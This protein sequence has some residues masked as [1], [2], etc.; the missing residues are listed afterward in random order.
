MK[1]SYRLIISSFFILISSSIFSVSN[2]APNFSQLVS[3][4]FY[5]Q[6][7]KITQE[8]AYIQ[9]D[10]PY[11]NAGEDIWFKGYVLNAA[12]HIPNS[13]S[14]FLYVEL[15]DKSDSVIS[16]VK[17]RKDSLGFYGNIKLNP[18]LQPGM[19]AIR[20]YTYYMQN[21][22]SDFFFSKNI[23]IGNSID[24]RVN[25]NIVYGKTI[26]NTIPVFLEFKNTFKSPIVDRRVKITYNGSE[27]SY[28]S[29]FLQTNKDG[30]IA[31]LIPYDSLLTNKYIEVRIADDDMKYSKKF[32]IPDFRNDFDLQ[33]F[34]ESGVFLNNI[35]QTIA[36]KAIGTNGLSTEITG[37]L[38]NSKGEEISDINSVNKGMGKFT[39]VASE[40]ETYYVIVKNAKGI[41]K[42]FELSNNKSVGIG[43]HMGKNRGKIYYQVFNN[44]ILPTNEYYLLIHSRGIPFVVQ[45]INKTE[46]IIPEELLPSGIVSFA[47]LDSLGNTYCERLMFI[48][49]NDQ[50]IITM[51]SD[52][53]NYAK[54][55]PVQLDF[56]IKSLRQKPVDGSFSISVTDS[57][58][59]KQ[60][61]L[62]NNI[63]SYF[64]LS[65][66]IKG[67]IEDPGS[68][69]DEDQRISNEKI[70]V[71]LLTQGWRRFSTDDIA[72]G[73]FNVQ[74][75][76]AEV[77]QAITGKVTNIFGKP[78]VNSEIIMLLGY[79]NQIS[80][81][82]T[83]SAG[84]YLIDGIE[85]PDSTNIVLKAKKY[86]NLADVEITP[87]ADVF[88]ETNMFIPESTDKSDLP[89]D[90]YFLQT[91][92]KYYTDGGMLVINL[93]ELT[94]KAEKK[95][96]NFDTDIYSGMASTQIKS[97][98]LEKYPGMS[99]LDILST[100][101]GVTVMGDEVSIRGSSHNP[102]FMI[103]GIETQE[104]QDLTYLTST[105]IESISVF[106]G[107]DAAIFGSKGGSGAVTI[108]LKKGA[109]IQQITP[110]SL[111]LIK[112]L[113]YQKPSEFYV[114]KYDVDS[115]LI[116]TKPDLR[117]TIYWNPT[118]VADS[119]GNVHVQFYTADKA[120]NYTLVFEGITDKGE[121]CRFKGSIR[122]EGF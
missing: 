53:T 103:D 60:D 15:L 82:K 28:K 49:N 33:F 62:G 59:V 40:N 10:K 72:K 90:D 88:P 87:D 108:T 48:Q 109:S 76:Y 39:L 65:S 91:K 22:S 89:P 120:S 97:D 12:T 64:L 114:P 7:A 25:C 55:E 27:K 112:P 31:W 79:K 68:Y 11:Y 45:K 41:Q 101:P 75:Y 13:V 69:F 81:T 70:D 94:V 37:V 113:G 84:N 9:T 118:L 95:K 104:M 14:R 17:I 106:K 66:D 20:A 51:K 4:R 46:G 23:Y 71:L 44:T 26:N 74:K 111:A 50:P 99:V 43:L 115:I 122:R 38:Y 2:E 63:L 58:I 42:R 107:A 78:N 21:V 3:S 32:F 100:V 77:G 93:H 86:K 83:D 105:D 116:S 73:K 30:R 121:I 1:K 19:F 6:W 85:F 61:T 24:D 8:K 52:K 56:N 35:L 67:Y 98:D 110:S 54:R 5:R 57:K 92:E 36:F 47:V 117:T 96:D 80:T 29:T 16:R 18:E 34:P 102:L 119:T